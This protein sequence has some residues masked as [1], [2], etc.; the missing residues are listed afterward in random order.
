[1]KKD[2]P[3]KNQLEDWKMFFKKEAGN[4]GQAGSRTAGQ[5]GNEVRMDRDEEFRANELFCF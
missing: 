1:M 2:A 4:G 5:T 3:V